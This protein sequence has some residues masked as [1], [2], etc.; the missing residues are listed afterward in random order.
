MKPIILWNLKSE[1]ENF[2]KRQNFIGPDMWLKAIKLL[3]YTN[4]SVLLTKQNKV[5]SSSESTRSCQYKSWD[6]LQTHPPKISA[7]FYNFQEILCM[8]VG[9]NSLL[10]LPSH[11]P[12]YTLPPIHQREYWHQVHPPSLS[13]R[14]PLHTLIPILQ[15]FS[16]NIVILY[17]VTYVQ[18]ALLVYTWTWR[19]L[20][21]LRQHVRE[22]IPEIKHF[23]IYISCDTWHW[24]LELSVINQDH[25]PPGGR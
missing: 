1:W 9:M 23:W 13:S 25:H 18:L 5:L 10:P 3:H 20:L 8:S 7:C 21:Q 19:W 17:E 6:L 24:W 15:L 22:F 16:C 12:L 4:A 2:F 11:G 14:G